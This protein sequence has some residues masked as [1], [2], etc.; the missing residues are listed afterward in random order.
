M[1]NDDLNYIKSLFPTTEK[2]LKETQISVDE[3]LGNIEEY[4]EKGKFD[5]KKNAEQQLILNEFIKYKIL[6]DQLFAYTQALNY[7]TTRFGSSDTYLK[8]DW[9]T[10]NAANYNLISN[11][12][13]VLGK[14]FIGK[15]SELLSNSYQALGAVMVTENPKI[16]AYTLSTLKRYATKKYMSLSDYEKI[17]NLIK[18]SFID[19][20]IQNNTT[21]REMIKPLLVDSQTAIVDQLEKAKQKYPS[22]QLLQDL[23]PVLGN[24]EKSAKS[25]TLKVNIK[26]AN[27]E[28]FYTGMMR[29]LRDSGEKDL[30]DL[31]T[32][33]INVSILQGTGQSAISIRNIIPIEDYAD[34]IAPIFQQL[35][36]N[37]MLEP[38]ENAMFE[39]NNFRNTD[40]FQEFRPGSY[41]VERINPNT[42][43]LDNV[44][45]FPSLNVTNFPKMTMLKLSDKYNSFNLSSDFLKVPKVI[46]TKNGTK[47]NALTGFVV[48]KA[49]YAKMKQKGD[50]N[51]FDAYYYKKVYTKS[52]DEF[53]NPIPLS[54]LNKKGDREYYYKLI[55]VYGDGDRA[56]EMNTNFTPSV[57]DN[58]SMRIPNEV[59]DE[60][61]VSMINPGI[62]EEIVPLPT[63]TS[64]QTVTEQVVTPGE[65][66][67]LFSEEDLGL[68]TDFNQ[69]DFKC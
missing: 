26:D 15:L 11:V 68:N 52:L 14:T 8:K 40:V 18:N 21:V 51:L 28:N 33:I 43:E 16:K 12:Q 4:G 6:A 44:Y 38:F 34:K 66:L 58:G 62:E 20:V 31:Y 56:V 1:N 46:T 36:A 13:D 42:G 27:S 63:E 19:F 35:Q 22:N 25:I 37:N 7:D 17:S 10:M 2:Q 59:S 45:E 9:G 60:Q 50:F 23:V 41:T 64:T 49:D 54:K 65:Q 67:E 39:R 30:Q 53:G 24:R 57:I 5:Q 32:N 55:N 69:D 3:L 47:V 61:I 48:S 29:E